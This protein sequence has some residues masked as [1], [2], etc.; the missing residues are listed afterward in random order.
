MDEET[1]QGSGGLSLSDIF[2]G[3]LNTAGSY[4]AARETRASEVAQAQIK[5]GT[6][7]QS[8]QAQV[9]SNDAT[10]ARIQ[11]IALWV[12]LA[13]LAVYALKKVK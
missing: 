5:Q 12:I 7:S 11:Q 6:A 3:V 13:M 8:L 10:N 9:Q 2:S 4:L 1:A